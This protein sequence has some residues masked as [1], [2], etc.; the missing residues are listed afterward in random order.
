M[1]QVPGCMVTGARAW[2]GW[3]CRVAVAARYSCMGLDWL[4]LLMNIHHQETGKSSLH[5]GKVCRL[6]F[7]FFQWHLFFSPLGMSLLLLAQLLSTE[8]PCWEDTV[9]ELT[10]AWL[11]S[12]WMFCLLAQPVLFHTAF[13]Q[14]N[15]F[16]LA[17]RSHPHSS[18]SPA[19][20]PLWS[21][22][23]GVSPH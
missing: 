15:S 12:S 16:V 3:K 8:I 14:S 18:S 13:P 19:M 2:K 21:P 5:W 7:A 9:S 4:S 10:L 22:Q 20:S 23:Q 17:Q 6:D 1:D 11:F